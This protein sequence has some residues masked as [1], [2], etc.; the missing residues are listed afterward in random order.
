M[1]PQVSRAGGQKA[2][3]QTLLLDDAVPAATAPSSASRVTS[4]SQRQ[5]V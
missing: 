3:S 2:P 5:S 4:R 1:A